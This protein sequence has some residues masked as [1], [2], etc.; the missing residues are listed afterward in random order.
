MNLALVRATAEALGTRVL[1]RIDDA[2]T[3]RLRPEYVQDI[4]RVLEWVGMVPDVGPHTP[5]DLN[6]WS[7]ATRR[8]RYWAALVAMELAG[9][10]VF[11]CT[12]SRAVLTDGSC[13]AGCMEPVA[14]Y[15]PTL[16]A[17]RLRREGGDVTLWGRYH[18]GYHLA[19]CVDDLDYGVT[20]VVRGADLATASV[21]HAQIHGFLTGN[22]PRYAHHPL[23]TGPDGAKLSKSQGTARLELDTALAQRIESMAADL[24][25]GIVAQFEAAPAAG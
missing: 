23:V 11:T 10:P 14:R 12:C 3:D 20:H 15:A 21:A 22:A 13:T 4:F 8:E 24:L 1:L 5:T 6:H 2:D 9:A 17:V 18:P 25:P 7:Q 19:S 16:S